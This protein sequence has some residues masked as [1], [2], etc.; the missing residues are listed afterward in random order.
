M[1]KPLNQQIKDLAKHIEQ[2]LNK[3]LSRK[4]IKIKYKTEGQNMGFDLLDNESEKYLR[5]LL[6]NDKIR[7]VDFTIEEKTCETASIVQNLVDC[8]YLESKNGVQYFLGGDGFICFARLTQKAKSYDELK[9]KYETMAKNNSNFTNN[10]N[11]P[12]TN[13]EG[14]IQNST[15]QIATE[16]S[17][18]TITNELVDE[19]I[20]EI[21]DKIETYGLS[22]DN[23]QELKDL[24]EDVKEK[25]QKKPNLIKRALKSIWDFAKDVGCSVLAS[26]I[27]IKCG[28]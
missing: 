6:D 9:Q 18:I 3:E 15:V 21:S 11:A 17:N 7:N 13:I 20:K 28:F 5:G 26:Y 19:I 23:K 22:D 24:I 25:Q 2:E 4:S 8:G 1:T 27:S 14:G 12:V 16:N 10:F